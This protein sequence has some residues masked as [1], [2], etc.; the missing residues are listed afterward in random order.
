M[1][2]NRQWM[3]DH[4]PT[5]NSLDKLRSEPALST[6]QLHWIC[7]TRSDRTGMQYWYRWQHFTNRVFCLLRHHCSDNLSHSYG[8]FMVLSLIGAYFV[9]LRL[10]IGCLLKLTFFSRTRWRPEN[11]R[12][13]KSISPRKPWLR[14][15]G[16]WYTKFWSSSWELHFARR[17]VQCLNTGDE[18]CSEQDVAPDNHIDSIKEIRKQYAP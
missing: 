2:E 8:G 12:I 17:F 3:R 10:R 4:F 13:Q 5:N 9:C 1:G 11:L 7:I 16:S 14:S 18:E 6:C 15:E